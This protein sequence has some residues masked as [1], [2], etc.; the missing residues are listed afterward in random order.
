MI[1][2]VAICTLRAGR[3]G[4]GE[5]SLYNLR[6]A[7]FGFS[8]VIYSRVNVFLRAEGYDREP[9]GK[10][11]YNTLRRTVLRLPGVE[12]VTLVPRTCRS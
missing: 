7:D 5:R 9:H 8:A 2:Q 1:V 10:E 3:M 11:F 12:A 6:H 4:L